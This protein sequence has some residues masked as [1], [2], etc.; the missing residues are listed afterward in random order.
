MGHI[1]LGRLPRTKAWQEVVGELDV[2]SATAAR[3][4]ART[5]TVTSSYLRRYSTREDGCYRPLLE[6]TRIAVASRSP[7]AFWEYLESFGLRDPKKLDGV[8]LLRTV[9]AAA[10]SRAG[11]GPRTAFSEIADQAFRETVLTYVRN[12]ADTLWGVSS[13]DVRLAFKGLAGKRGFSDLAR[14]W[15]GQFVGRSLLYFLDRELSNHVGSA[16]PIATSTSAVDFERSVLAYA[17]ERTQIIRDFAPGWLSK[18]LWKEGELS[19]DAARK[20][21]AYCVKK[22]SEDIGSEGRG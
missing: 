13:E 21:Y 9:A 6:L 22:I 15:F 4:A 10:S 8:Q 5:F 14:Q 18:T 20:F 3:L 17:H 16:G 2:P 12:A 7:E 19:L 1:R 11:P